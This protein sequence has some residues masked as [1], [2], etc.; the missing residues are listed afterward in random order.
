MPAEIL[1]ALKPKGN[2]IQFMEM[3][4]AVLF[5]ATFGQFCWD[6]NVTFFCDNVAQQGSLSKGFTRDFDNAVLAGVFWDMVAEKGINLW[7]ERVT[8]EENLSDVPTREDDWA[9]HP[10]M[11]YFGVEEA[12]AGDMRPCYRALHRIIDTHRSLG[13][14]SASLF[15]GESM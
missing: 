5:V 1:S 8:S 6:G 14:P 3:S 11:E 13:F 15:S 4:A 12:P 7:V 9:A 2:Y 10:V